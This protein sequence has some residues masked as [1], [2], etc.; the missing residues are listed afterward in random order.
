M[1][2]FTFFPI[3]HMVS[4]IKRYIFPKMFTPCLKKMSATTNF[5]Y[6]SV[7]Y[8]E[9]FLWELD[10]DSAGSVKSV[11]FYQVSVI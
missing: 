9:V 10:C 5:H 4:A 3:D 11:R 8:I 1:H 6:K 2:V 7:R